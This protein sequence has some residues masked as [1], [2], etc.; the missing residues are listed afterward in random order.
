MTE[1]SLEDHIH[2]VFRSRPINDPA[3]SSRMDFDLS[4]VSDP[5]ET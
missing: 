5:P 3:G 1:S 2:G 4:L